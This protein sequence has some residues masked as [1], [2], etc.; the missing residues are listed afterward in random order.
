MT[1]ALQPIDPADFVEQ[2]WA[3]GGGHTTELAVDT[4]HQ[5]WNWRISVA[6]LDDGATFSALPGVRR[7]FAPLDG[8]V[9]LDFGD[10]TPH[11]V[12][13]LQTFAF[14]GASPP[15]CRIDMP[16]ARAFNL[17]LRGD[18]AGTLSVRPLLGSM[19]L[20]PQACT[21]WLVYVLAGQADL[22]ASDARIALHTGEAAWAQPSP[23]NRVRVEG[24]GE[25]ALVRIPA[26]SPHPD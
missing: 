11:T 24:G 25:L 21:R 4:D 5:P 6:R 19:V 1:T 18:A 2:A 17:M 26:G 16:G 7:Q 12:L 14:D 13:R 23:G 8:S 9:D 22:V 10:A 3:G 15:T 20:L